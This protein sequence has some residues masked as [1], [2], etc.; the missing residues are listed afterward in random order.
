[1][2]ATI[3]TTGTLARA[4]GI[5]VETVRNLERRGVLRPRRDATGR[6]IFGPQDLRRIATYQ[7]G[8][9]AQ[10]APV[11]RKDVAEHPAAEEAQSGAPAIAPDL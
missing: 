10:Q 7:R 9:T 8:R 3:Y 6:R 11:R 5:S 1:M 2:P 4:A